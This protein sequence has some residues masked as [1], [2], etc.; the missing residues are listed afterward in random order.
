MNLK[1]TTL[2]C[3]FAVAFAISSC[4]GELEAENAQL[5][6]ELE[7][8][9]LQLKEQTKL[10]DFSKEQATTAKRRADEAEKALAECNGEK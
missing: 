7:A 9:K 3:T 8:T 10:S 1:L 6:N 4:S 5:K 2:A